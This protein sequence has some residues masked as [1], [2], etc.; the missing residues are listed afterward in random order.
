MLVNPPW[1]SKKVKVPQSGNVSQLNKQA[2]DPHQ[3]WQL[4]ILTNALGEMY[5]VEGI[6]SRERVTKVSGKQKQFGK[7]R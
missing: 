5:P 6:S 4:L 2:A 1:I 3:K 7:F